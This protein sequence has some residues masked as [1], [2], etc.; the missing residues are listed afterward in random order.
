MV[1]ADTVLKNALNKLDHVLVIGID[2]NGNM[3]YSTSINQ[4]E[5]LVYWLEEFKTHLIKGVYFE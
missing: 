1:P 2:K 4:K 5:V 3:N